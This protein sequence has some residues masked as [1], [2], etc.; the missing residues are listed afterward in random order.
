[1]RRLVDYWRLF[2][3]TILLTAILAMPLLP[4][5][6]DAIR[7]FSEERRRFASVQL[8]MTEQQVIAVLGKPPGRYGPDEAEYAGPPSPYS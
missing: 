1:M 4:A 2:R 5:G 8:G 7:G 6:W 3:P